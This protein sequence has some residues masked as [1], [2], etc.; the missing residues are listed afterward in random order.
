MA[1]QP[2]QQ[3]LQLCEFDLRLPLP[4][5]RAVRKNVE[6]EL[7]PIDDAQ[8][9]RLVEV[10][11]LGGRELVIAD[12]QVDA[13]LVARGGQFLELAAPDER[14]RVGLR[15]LLDHPQRRAA[16]RCEHQAAE[17]L[18]RLLGVVAVRLAWR[19]SDQRDAFVGNQ[20]VI[21][22]GCGLLQAF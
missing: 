1:R 21:P 14:G 17:L 20:D 12:D 3:V 19:E 15:A 6:N 5:P 9:Q 22:G 16:A 10:A 8:P 2:G 13:L 18:E 7:C 4:G 11:H